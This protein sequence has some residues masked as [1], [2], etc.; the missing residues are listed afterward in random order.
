MV[1]ER[2][3][4][5]ARQTYQANALDKPLPAPADEAESSQDDNNLMANSTSPPPP[6]NFDDGYFDDDPAYVSRANGGTTK[7]NETKKRAAVASKPAPQEQYTILVKI[8]AERSWQET[9]RRSL[10]AASKYEGNDHIQLAV[11]GHN[12]VMEFPNLSTRAC[13]ELLTA[14]RRMSGVVDVV[15]QPHLFPRQ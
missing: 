14:L 1:R 8:K 11:S 15:S 6:P 13:P 2:P 10:Q 4:R 9:I 5:Q 3:Q 7:P 12:Q